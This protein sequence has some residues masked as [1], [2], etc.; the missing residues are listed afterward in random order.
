MA[1]ECHLRSD[2]SNEEYRQDAFNVATPISGPRGHTLDWTIFKVY[3]TLLYNMRTDFKINAVPKKQRC[4]LQHVTEGFTH[5]I[6]SF[7]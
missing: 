3:M 1:L 6:S 2:V 4:G 7:Q 5:F